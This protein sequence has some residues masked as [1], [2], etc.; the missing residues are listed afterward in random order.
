MIKQFSN[1]RFLLLIAV[2]LGIIILLFVFTR[3]EEKTFNSEILMVDTAQV[4]KMVITPKNNKS[5]EIIFTRTGSAWKLESGGKAYVADQGAIKN[6]LTEMYNIRAERVAATEPKSWPDYHLTDTAST[7]LQ[8]F[9]REGLLKDMLIGKLSYNVKDNEDLLNPA[10]QN[11][12]TMFSYVRLMG[13]NEIYAVGGFLKIN[14][15]PNLSAY[16]DKVLFEA[17]GEKINTITFRYPGNDVFSLTKQN[18]KWMLGSS[19]T[20]SASVT[21]YLKVFRK[22]SAN[23][24]IDEARTVAPVPTH[25]VIIEGNGFKPVELQAYLA[26]DSLYKFIVTSSRLPGGKFNGRHGSL[27]SRIFVQK[28]ELLKK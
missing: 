14:I 24:F 5:K 6:I 15:Q 9:G 16:R 20:D 8:L 10:Q 28:D 7:R 26:V 12:G 4:V 23:E 3:S 1:P 13:G 22:L 19:P 2:V 18:G 27:F 21:R 25:S 17:E 11:R